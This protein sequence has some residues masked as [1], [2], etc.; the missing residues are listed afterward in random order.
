[1]MIWLSPFM[2]PLLA[3]FETS[4]V[5]KSKSELCLFHRK[6]HI[7]ITIVL[8]GNLINSPN[9]MYFLDSKLQWGDHV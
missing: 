3:V 5:N 2:T 4:K 6:D 1:M 7:T 9:K 8:N